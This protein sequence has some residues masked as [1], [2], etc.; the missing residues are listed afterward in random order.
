MSKQKYPLVSNLENLCYMSNLYWTDAEIRDLK[1]LDTVR[2]SDFVIDYRGRIGVV[3]YADKNATSI[4]I[5]D[6]RLCD[7][8]L[9]GTEYVPIKLSETKIASFLSIWKDRLRR[10]CEVGNNIR[11]AA[12]YVYEAHTETYAKIITLSKCEGCGCEMYLPEKTY[13]DKD[14]CQPCFEMRFAKCQHCYNVTPREEGIM[15]SDGTFYCNKCKARNFILPYHHGY[16]SVTFYGDTQHNKVPYMGMELEVEVGGER[17]STVAKIMPIMNKGENYFI[18]CSHDGSLDNGFEIITQPA[19]MQYHYSIRNHYEAMCNKLKSL[20]YHS[21]SSDNCGLHVHF[22]RSFFS[23]AVEGE[24][25]A[26]KRF[27]MMVDKF[28]DELT[29]FAR[30]PNFRL[31]RYAKKLDMPVNTFVRKSNKS[32]DHDYRYY[33]VNITNK[34]T[35]ELRLFRGTLNVSTIM[36]TLQLVD[37][38]AIWC[39]NHSTSELDG[40][41]FE[42]FITT[43]GQKRYWARHRAIPDFEE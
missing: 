20:N 36:A 14:Y 11:L 29:V 31:R 19:T 27:V 42:T 6:S 43:T 33:G 37:N 28:W 13:K 24:A 2:V 38:M 1:V 10:G 7:I 26:T 23:D 32:K 16:P 4:V 18:Y 35:I 30:R 39:K 22:N 15:A 25:E 12:K 9:D 40:L 17:D 8:Y 41:T 34:D 3:I 21:H 5:I